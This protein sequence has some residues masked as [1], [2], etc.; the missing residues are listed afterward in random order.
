MMPAWARVAWRD[1][2]AHRNEGRSAQRG[3][4]L[5]AQAFRRL[6]QPD[7]AHSGEGRAAQPGQT[8][9]RGDIGRQRATRE[10]FDPV[11]ALGGTRRQIG[12]HG[13]RLL[14]YQQ[15]DGGLPGAAVED[16]AADMQQV[17]EIVAV[18]GAEQ[19]QGVW[20]GHRSLSQCIRSAT[21]GCGKHDQP[22]A[23]FTDMKVVLA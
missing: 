15:H 17:A 6:R 4:H 12:D 19:D 5:G 13:L 22:G 11:F 2:V 14:R 7:A 16:L 20:H 23:T 18:E 8:H 9:G 1:A 10:A 21:A 3:Q